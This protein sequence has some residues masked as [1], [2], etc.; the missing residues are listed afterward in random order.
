LTVMGGELSCSVMLPNRSAAVIWRNVD[1]GLAERRRGAG[2][3]GSA[4]VTVPGPLTWLQS[5]EM[6]PP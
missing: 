2:L 5:T 4:K 1:S 6:G 3:R